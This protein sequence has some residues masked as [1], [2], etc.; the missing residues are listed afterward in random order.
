MSVAGNAITSEGKILLTAYGKEKGAR[1]YQSDLM[2]SGDGGHRWRHFSTIGTAEPSLI[3]S[4]D[5][6]EG[7]N[8]TALLRLADGGLMAVYRV[9]SGEKWK[10]RRSYSHDEGRSWTKPEVLPGYS[11]RPALVRTA[12]GTIALSTGRPGIDLWLSTDSA[13]QTWQ[14][15]DVIAYHNSRALDPSYRIGLANGRTGLQTNS[16]TAMT[17][18]A[19]NR[20]LLIYDRDGVVRPPE[21]APTGPEDISRIFVLPIEVERM[22]GGAGR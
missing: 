18:V 17:E 2:V 10:L 11:V 3:S 5:R 9:G 13:A 19:P 15:I 8:E 21:R 16:Y 22:A 6:Y 12:N 7:P 1:F 4:P 20:L 14:R